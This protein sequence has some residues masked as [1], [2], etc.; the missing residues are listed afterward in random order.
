M[1]KQPSYTNLEEYPSDTYRRTMTF[2]RKIGRVSIHL[3]QIVN[4][5]IGKSII[6]F[7]FG[8]LFAKVISK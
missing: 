1:S 3:A 6:P 8:F 2:F 7:T 5:K 4:R